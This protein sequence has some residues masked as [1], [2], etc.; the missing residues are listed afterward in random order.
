[1]PLPARLRG[2]FQSSPRVER[3]KPV[4][5]RSSTIDSLASLG[6]QPSHISSRQSEH[7]IAAT[8]NSCGSQPSAANKHSSQ[9]H[10]QEQNQTVVVFDFDD[11]LFPTTYVDRLSSSYDNG[12]L[13]ADELQ[14]FLG[15]IEKCQA[16]AETLLQCARN[17][18][19]VMIVTLC[20][21]RLLTKRCETWF[22]RVWKLINDSSMRMVYARE[23]QVHER[24]SKKQ[25]RQN[26]T[27]GYW[28]WVKGT[29]IEQELDTFYSQYTGQSWK[30]VISIGDSNVE[31]YGVLGAS[32]A[33]VQKRFSGS[34]TQSQKK[35]YVD[36]WER[37]DNNDPKWRQGLEGV[38]DGHIFK[39]R[40]KVVKMLEQPMPVELEQ[41]QKLLS[42]WFPSITYYDGCL[43]LLIDDLHNDKT[44]K[45]LESVQLPGECHDDVIDFNDVQL[46]LTARAGSMS[47]KFT[48][49]TRHSL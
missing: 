43:N 26:E 6:S 18:G 1:M 34:S 37:F 46:A 47:L 23:S 7:S 20:T 12:S 33:Y 8:I 36:I 32:N 2:L 38:H 21:R 40:T 11:T 28:A 13:M 5:V 44:R 30:N 25:S 16:S 48:K 29:V 3:P 9:I 42:L 17:L 35:S 4:T 22:P 31:R 10:F 19:H 41:Q 24:E 45:Q 15:K 14:D 27:T 39:V 49:E